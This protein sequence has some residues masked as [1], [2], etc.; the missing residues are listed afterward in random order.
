MILTKQ[1]IEMLY[2]D[3]SQLNRRITWTEINHVMKCTWTYSIPTGHISGFPEFGNNTIATF[4]DETEIL[5]VGSNN[6]D[7]TKKLQTSITS[8]NKIQN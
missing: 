2:R 3:I 5:V 6:K 8:I 1:F 4:N 7:A